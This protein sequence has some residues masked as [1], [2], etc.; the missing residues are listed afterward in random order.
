LR[1]DNF[2]EKFFEQKLHDLKRDTW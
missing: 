2:I 1:I